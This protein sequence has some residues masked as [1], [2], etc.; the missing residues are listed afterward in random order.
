MSDL[1]RD[2][3]GGTATV[4][5]SSDDGRTSAGGRHALDEEAVL[6]PI[7]H[8]LTRGGWRSRQ[9]EPAAPS[10]PPRAAADP[11]DAFRRDPLTAPIPVQA[12]VPAPTPS[13][14]RAAGPQAVP[15]A[16][17]AR[18]DDGH[19]HR[20]RHREETLTAGW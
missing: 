4:H 6:T 15:P 8:A 3:S 20:N 5:S 12:L 7:F 13:W 2:L 18:P 9:H 11:V 14:R 10:V 17:H 16:R 1:M 19:H